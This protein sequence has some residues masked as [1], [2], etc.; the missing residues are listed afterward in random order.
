MD[1]TTLNNRNIPSN[2]DRTKRRAQPDFMWTYLAHFGTAMWHRRDEVLRFDFPLWK[3]MTEKMAKNGLNTLVVDVGEAMIYPTHPELRVKGSWEPEKVRDEIARLKKLGILAVPKLNF[4]TCH[5]AWLGEYAKMVST[6]EYYRVC[7]DLIRDTAEVFN[8]SPLLHLGYD[9]EEYSDQKDYDHVVIRQGELWW[10]D[11]LWFLEETR[12]YGFR[13][14]IWSDYVWDHEK[15]FM[16]RMPKDVLQSNWY[17]FTAF[18]KRRET[19]F[20]RKLSDA[21]FDQVP[22]SSNYRVRENCA[23]TALHCRNAIAPE[24]LKGFMHAP[25]CATIE[26]NRKQLLDGVTLLGDVRAALAGR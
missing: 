15:E 4:S 1:A 10:H 17:Y 21:G 18:D 5:D 16:E 24:R 7:A 3:E 20:Y 14:W 2:I 13:P 9:E 12:K 8:E 25:W 22:C 11:F 26:K 6:P 19:P 23:L